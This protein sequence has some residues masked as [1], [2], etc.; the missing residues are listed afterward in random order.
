MPFPR[1]LYVEV[2]NAVTAARHVSDFVLAGEPLFARW[3]SSSEA[4]RPSRTVGEPSSVPSTVLY[5][6]AG[7]GGT[8]AWNTAAGWQKGVK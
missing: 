7:S 6:P 5:A 2:E 8:A 4:V 3:S 1:L